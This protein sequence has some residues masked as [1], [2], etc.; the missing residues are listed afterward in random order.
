MYIGYDQL[1]AFVEI[2]KCTIIAAAAAR[3]RAKT[4]LSL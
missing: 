2:R 4:L 3:V 1:I